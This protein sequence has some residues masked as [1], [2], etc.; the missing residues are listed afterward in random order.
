MLENSSL[1]VLVNKSNFTKS[2][3]NDSTAESVSKPIVALYTPI[4]QCKLDI[5][6]S[7]SRRQ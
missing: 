6:E 1:R 7:D 3:I 2:W 4:G 5:Q